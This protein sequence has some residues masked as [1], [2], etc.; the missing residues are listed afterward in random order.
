MGSFKAF[1]LAFALLFGP[2]AE[3]FACGLEAPVPTTEQQAA[4]V[5]AD[6]AGSQGDTQDG[7]CEHGHCHHG[8]WVITPHLTEV[9]VQAVASGRSAPPAC[10]LL[11]SRSTSRLE[12]PPRA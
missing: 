3:A 11:M 4:V 9:A 2:V 7:I 12:R 5:A 1:L 8:G 6:Q 10:G